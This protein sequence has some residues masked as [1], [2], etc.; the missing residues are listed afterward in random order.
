LSVVDDAIDMTVF[1]GQDY[2]AAGGADRISTET[3]FKEHAFL[4]ETVE[5]WCFIYFTSVTAHRM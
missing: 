5:V 4:S 3:I 1:A 2:G